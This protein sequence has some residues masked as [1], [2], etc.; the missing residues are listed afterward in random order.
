[1]KIFWQAGCWRLHPKRK[2]TPGTKPFSELR[3]MLDLREDLAVL[4]ATVRSGLDPDAAAR[5]GEAPEVRFPAG[6]RYIAPAFGAA[7][8]I[9]FGLYMAGV[10]TR[11]PFL[12]VLFAEM[13]YAFF[14]GTANVAR[15]PCSGFAVARPGFAGGAPR[16]PGERN[17]PRAAASTTACA[18]E[19]WKPTERIRS[20]SP[21][22]AGWVPVSTGQE[23][24]VFQPIAFAL[25]WTAQVAMAIERWRRSSGRHIREWIDT[26]GEFEAL[27]SLAGYSYEHPADV[28]P[29]L[30]DI[31]GGWFEAE[32]LAHP[33]MPE[34][35]SIRNDVR[36]GGET[37]LWI[38]SGS[39][40][41]G[42][43]TLLRTI[44]INTVLAWAGAPV[45]AARLK[46]SPL[47]LGASIRVL[48]SLQDGRS[49]FYAE[50]TRLREI[51]A[52]TSGSAPGSVLAG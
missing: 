37:R 8:V 24:K 2:S 31:A 46:I 41:S 16:A 3:A 43:S 45:R 22:S 15:H 50:I 44:G 4:G 38:V 13:G 11:T 34:A 40:M 26:A 36:L 51:V 42:K 23:N 48:D 20:R 7:I 25:L 17:F 19:A 52:L 29:D 12:A 39:N 5:W 21:T 33:L 14:L 28:F 6:A 9:S 30:A 49:R 18:I 35:H 27:C 1:M 47:S 32:A 10:F